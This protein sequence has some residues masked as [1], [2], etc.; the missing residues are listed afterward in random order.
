MSYCMCEAPDKCTQKLSCYR[1]RKVPHEYSQPWAMLFGPHPN[2]PAVKCINFVAIEGRR[3]R[4][5]KEA[6]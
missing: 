5:M 4:E 2:D 6:R 1:Y 3:V